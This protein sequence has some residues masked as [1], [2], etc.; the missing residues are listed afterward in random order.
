MPELSNQDSTLAM[1]RRRSA[2]ALV[3]L[4]ASLAFKNV[5]PTPAIRWQ[6]ALSVELAVCV[7]AMALAYPRFGSLSRRTLAWLGAIWVALV[8]VRYADVTA[9]ALYG[10]PVNLFWDMRHVSA[11]AAMLARVASWRLVLLII[12]ATILIPFVLY[13][14]DSVGARTRERGHEP[15]DR[16]AS[17]R[18]AGCRRDRAVR[19][20][21]RVQRERLLRR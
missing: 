10:R 15:A 8:I 17:P 13:T 7:L 4:D 11:V 5:W 2:A 18:R 14:G 20:R 21:T 1:A 9:P 19:R 3:V 16:T 12:A 6:G